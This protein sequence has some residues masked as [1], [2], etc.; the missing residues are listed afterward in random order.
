MSKKR[1]RDELDKDER[2]LK[3][4]R[5]HSKD[6]HMS[7]ARLNRIEPKHKPSKK[8]HINLLDV[9]EKSGETYEGYED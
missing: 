7:N 6:D 1:E 8:D 5:G 9:Y 3:H 2:I 4:E